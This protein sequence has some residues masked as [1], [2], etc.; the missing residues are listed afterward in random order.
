MRLRN[1]PSAALHSR[2]FARPYS[3][4]LRFKRPVPG[5]RLPLSALGGQKVAEREGLTVAGSL[6]RL[7]EALLRFAS[8]RFK[9]PVPG[10]RLPLSAL[11]GTESGGERGIRTP[12]TFRLNG[13]QDR[14]IRP[15]CHLS[16]RE[17]V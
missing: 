8:L 9:R 12:G 5:V 1:E 14:R 10:V 13:F 17:I 3:A 7:R 16:G 4:S 6:P 15:L 11:G 2:D